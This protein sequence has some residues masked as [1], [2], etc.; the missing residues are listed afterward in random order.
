MPIEGSLTS[1]CAET[2]ENPPTICMAPLTYQRLD[3][4]FVRVKFLSM[5][6]NNSRELLL[7]DRSHSQ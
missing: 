3:D 6:G 5:R 2:E 4:H 1:K 7:Y